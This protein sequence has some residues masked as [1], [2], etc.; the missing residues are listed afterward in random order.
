MIALAPENKKQI[1]EN[2]QTVLKERNRLKEFFENKTAN[3]HKQIDFLPQVQGNNTN[4]SIDGYGDVHSLK[5][6]IAATINK[7]VGGPIYDEDDNSD[8]VA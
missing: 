3:F 5:C 2:I 8:S 6:G 4:F 7:A 1:Q